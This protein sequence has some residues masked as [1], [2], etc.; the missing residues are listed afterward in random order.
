MKQYLLP[1]ILLP[2]ACL[3]QGSAASDTTLTSMDSL[4]IFR[5]LDSLMQNLDEVEPNN[6]LA[7]RAGYNSNFNGYANTTGL[8]Q[9][10]LSTG[11]T[12][13]HKSGLFA[14]VTGYASNQFDPYYYQTMASV[15]Y[16][17]SSLKKFSFQAEYRKSLYHFDTGQSAD[18]YPDEAYVK[19]VRG[20]ATFTTNYASAIYSNALTGTLY[21]EHKI[22]NLRLDYTLY[23]EK[24]FKPA[25][26]FAPTVSINLEKRKWLKTQRI[27]IIP[28]VS[29]L[30]GSYSYLYYD[31]ERLFKTR[32]E[33]L[34]RIQKNLPLFKVVKKT[35]TDWQTLNWSFSLPVYVSWKRFSTSLAYTFVMPDNGGYFMCSVARY[36][37]FKNRTKKLP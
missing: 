5:L 13:Y 19:T 29:W 16:M 20:L 31:Y 32:L 30:Y 8:N 10:G 37:D 7:I 35:T 17:N 2:C 9:Y 33:A 6:Q 28:S 26:R 25:N 15:G 36:I 4:S 1:L 12:F 21:F 3:A 34:I 14:D 11:L 24:G 22:L 18:Q 27:A 23:G